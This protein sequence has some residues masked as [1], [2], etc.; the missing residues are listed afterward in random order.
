MTDFKTRVHG[1]Y[2][3]AGEHTVLRG[4]T[5][6]VLPLYARHLDLIC[7]DLNE[8]LSLL[9]KD[10]QADSLVFWGLIEK[11]LELSGHRRE[12]LK[13]KIEIVNSIPVGAGLGASAAICVAM[14]KYFEHLGWVKSADLFLFSKKLEDLF[15]GESSGADVAV[16]LRG[17]GLCFTKGHD[18]I[19][20]E[21]QLKP[22]F[23]LSYCGRSAKT[24]EC[25][26]KVKQLWNRDS[27]LATEIDE[28]MKESVRRMELALKGQGTKP[29][30]D[31]AEAMTKARTCF[32]RWGL[33]EGPLQSHMLQLLEAG[34]LS[35]KP[36]G[37]GGGGYVLSLWRKPPP[38]SLIHQLM[39]G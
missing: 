1:K 34:A 14:A 26:T 22:Q 13:G 12:E 33:T 25:V 5:A 27:Y 24:S 21:N 31:L 10:P 30:E 9:S 20:L 28:E 4:G 37:S 38:E 36:T 2:I 29:L 18:P 16:A 15:H 11:A 19:K 6:L 3:L 35:V 8:P 17:E 23:Y 7:S 39:K 32:E